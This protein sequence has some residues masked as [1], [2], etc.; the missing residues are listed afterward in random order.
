[1]VRL[2][3]LPHFEPFFSF[4]LKNF[5]FLLD[6]MYIMCYNVYM[7]NKYKKYDTA[8]AMV[9]YHLVFCPR[10]QRK[11]FLIAG[12]KERFKELV[13]QICEQKNYDILLLNCDEDH[14]HIYVGVSPTTS[15]HD[16]L[17]AIKGATSIA[18]R[19][20]F[21]ALSEMPNLWT[22]SYLASTEEY[23]SRETIMQYLA[24]QKRILTKK[25]K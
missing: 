22:R 3:I 4:F 8:T 21:A 24:S 20:E 18:I 9:N 25:E 11:I 10:Y 23:L 15:P 1:M 7:E 2:A 16:V 17:K 19:K 5:Q 12:V 6:K 14:C 13:H